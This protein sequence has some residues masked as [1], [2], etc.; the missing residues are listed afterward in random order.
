[1]SAKCYTIC[2][3]LVEDI[4]ISNI[5]V[6]L[7]LIFGPVVYEAILHKDFLCLALV[8]ILFI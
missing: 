7:L 6:K 4:I 8:A 5:C 1:M 2:A 3:I